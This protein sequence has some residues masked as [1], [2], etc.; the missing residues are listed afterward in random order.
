ML[1]STHPASRPPPSRR[2]ERF[3][4][5]DRERPCISAMATSSSTGSRPGLRNCVE[6]SFAAPTRP[7]H[8]QA[9]P[10]K[11][12]MLLRRPALSLT[13]STPLCLDVRR[14]RTITRCGTASCTRPTSHHGDM[15]APA[16]PSRAN[17]PAGLD[18]AAVTHTGAVRSLNEDSYLVTPWVC[19]VADGMGGHESGEVASTDDRRPVRSRRERAAGSISSTSSR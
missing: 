3:D 12:Y 13:A 2:G 8:R 9:F 18:A 17:D 6:L 19:L 14:G 4:T 10:A 11:G 16:S 15:T 7:P 1:I 5:I